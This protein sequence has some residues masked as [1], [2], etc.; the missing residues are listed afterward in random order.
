MSALPTTKAP[1]QIAVTSWSPTL[2][3]RTQSLRTQRRSRGGQRWKLHV[4]YAP[5]KPDDFMA[6]TAFLNALRGQFTVFTLA[7]ST[8][9]VP[10]GTWGGTP[11][12]AGAAVAGASS[13][14]IDGLTH[15]VTGIGKAGD[16]VKF[17]G[18]AKVYQASADFNS[19]SGGAATLPIFPNLVAAVADNE[20]LTIS[21]VPFSVI[22]AGDETGFEATPGAPFG[23]V[24]FDCIE[25]Y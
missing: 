4:A 13:V 5:L 7:L 22:L 12:A 8:R 10:R 3:S 15:G 2:V 17:A 1:A 9:I 18:H 23:Q 14:A 20:V 6:L 11:L 21:S 19:D 24:S 25:E 16:F